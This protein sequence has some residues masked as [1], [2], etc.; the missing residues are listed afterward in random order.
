MLGLDWTVSQAGLDLLNELVVCFADGGSSD[1]R[2]Q[3][4]DTR[5][6]HR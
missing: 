1:A 3:R 2:E 6:A 4:T 5:Q